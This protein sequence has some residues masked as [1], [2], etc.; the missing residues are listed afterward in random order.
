MFL[1]LL[2]FILIIIMFNHCYYV[3]EDM[4][5]KTIC[6][7]RDSECFIACSSRKHNLDKHCF[8]QCKI[9]SPIC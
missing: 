9:H 7:E 5:L 4:T 8:E 1:I 2:L 3:K 6:T